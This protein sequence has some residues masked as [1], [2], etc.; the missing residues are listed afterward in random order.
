MFANCQLFGLDL[1]FP[2]VCLTPMPMPV[3][4]P[5]PNMALGFTAT[6]HTC[7]VL[8]AGLPAHNMATRI[9]SSVGDNA[10]VNLGVVSGTVMGASRHLTGAFTTLIKGSP[11]TRLTSLT[12]QNGTNA[13]GMRL[14]PSQ[15][16]VMLLGL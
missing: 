15:C 12:L 9:W 11:A 7:K 14:I 5:Y 2:D 4:V 1:A 8:F 3:P 13:V 16:K 10:G 6:P